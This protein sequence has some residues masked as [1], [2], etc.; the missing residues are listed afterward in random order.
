MATREVRGMQGTLGEGF[1]V[2]EA[3][4]ALRALRASAM[5]ESLCRHGTWGRGEVRVNWE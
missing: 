4:R 3:L 1:V 5:A 2:L